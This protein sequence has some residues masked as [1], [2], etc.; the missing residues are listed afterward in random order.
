MLAYKSD[1]RFVNFIDGLAN[2]VFSNASLRKLLESFSRQR[3]LPDFNKGMWCNFLAQGLIDRGGGFELAGNQPRALSYYE[4]AYSLSKLVHL[5]DHQSHAFQLLVRMKNDIAA[6][7]IEISRKSALTEN[8]AMAAQYFHDALDLFADKDL[9]YLDGAWLK[10]YE[11]WLFLNFASQV[12][13]CIEMKNYSKALIYLNEIQN[14]C[15]TSSSY[16][17]PDQFHEWMRSV[18]EGIYHD[19]LIRATN[20]LASDELQEAEQLFRQAT[21]MRM[22]AGYRIEKDK[23]EDDLERRFLQILYDE[24]IEKGQTNFN[25]EEFSNALYYFDEANFQERNNILR[26]CPDL[27][28]YRQAAAR[29]VMETILS[30]G[31]LKAWAYDL[32]G[33][34]IALEQVKRMLSEYSFA[35]I[36]TLSLQYSA[37]N[38]YYHQNECE[39]VYRE[40]NDLML[41][42]QE[43]KESNDFILALKIAEDAVNLSMDNLGCRIRDD[44]AWYQ[45]VVLESPADFQQKEKMLE[46]FNGTCN[47]YLL[48]FQDLK[49]FYY[50]NKLLDLGVV[51]IPLYDRVIKLKDSLLLTGMV[52]HYITLKDFDNA[53]HILDRL[54]ELGYSPAPLSGQQK[55][56]AEALARRDAMNSDSED[57]RVKLESY[58]GQDKWYREFADSYKHTWLQTTS[59]KIKYWPLIW[60]K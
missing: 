31:R 6:S 56:L 35:E 11:Q 32:E 13:K 14:Q 51:F 1:F 28:S 59:W 42:V 5:H 3:D 50:Q 8:P 53:F 15:R 54:R 19:L 20:L 29:K 21:E 38:N 22:R 52:G 33:A 30:D 26:P 25:K 58:T 23:S 44:D 49:S 39:K 9:V 24:L 57:P 18:H 60:K 7:F 17:C 2:P 27:F 55:A 47:E 40:F 4:S 36:D 10:D 34:G 46:K 48:A 43:A 41:K 45:K 37:L 12:V 16:P